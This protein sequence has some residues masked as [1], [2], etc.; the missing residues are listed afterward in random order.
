MKQEIRQWKTED[1]IQ[2]LNSIGKNLKERRGT[3]CKMDCLKR[4]LKAMDIRVDW[5]EIEPS[6]V[7]A[8]VNKLLSSHI[9]KSKSVK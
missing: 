5:G 8:H 6:I 3:L 4:Y 9:K 2:Y 7:R 1:E